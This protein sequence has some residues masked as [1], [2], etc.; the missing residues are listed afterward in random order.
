MCFS[1]TASFGLSGVLTGLGAVALARNEEPPQRMFAAVPLLFAAQ[2][3]AEGTVWATFDG[4]SLELHR[5][6]VTAFLAFAMVIWPIWLPIALHRAEREPRRRRALAAIVAAGLLV[7][8]PAAVWLARGE[9]T[10][11]IAGRCIAYEMGAERGVHTSTWAL[12]CYI[13]PTVLPFF[14]SSLRLTRWLGALIVGSLLATVTAERVALTSVWCFF[15]AAISGMIIW[16]VS[17]Q[18]AQA[19][20]FPAPAKR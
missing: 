2:Q 13:V 9:F 3:A 12:F 11:H 5:L 14:V 19:R 15:A 6:A 4:G 17:P 1:A 7:A 10:A 20:P 18:G 16:I 8:T